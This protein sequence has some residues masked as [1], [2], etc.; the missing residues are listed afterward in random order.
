MKNDVAHGLTV[1]T[2]NRD[3]L[4][5]RA[6]PLKT[7]DLILSLSKDEAK[8]SCF[9]SGL[10]V[11]ILF[12]KATLRSRKELAITLTDDSDIAAAAMIGESRIPKKG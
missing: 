11:L 9:F 10:L 12:Y 3:R 7:R 8:I 4:T 6:K 1:S 2:P 5:M